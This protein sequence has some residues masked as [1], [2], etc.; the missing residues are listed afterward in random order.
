[1][2]ATADARGYWL[3]DA[4]GRVFRYGDAASSP[5][6]RPAHPIIGLAGAPGGGFYLFSAHGNVY[7]LAGARFFGS[8]RSSHVSTITGMG[9]TL[10]GKGYWLIDSA[11]KIFSYGDAAK[12]SPVKSTYSFR[13][14][15]AAPRGG[16]WAWTGHGNIDN[17]GGAPFYGSPYH[18][19]YRNSTFRGLTPTKARDG[20]WMAESGGLVL[21]FG[22][23]EGLPAIQPKHPIVGLTG[24]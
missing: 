1:M 2:A 15:L 14:I 20:Y 11:G 16:A 18:E 19:G 22:K 12:L 13:G 23:A 4:A 17:V 8:A 9:V 24:G 3:A 5:G 7:N 21:P 10:D 6:V